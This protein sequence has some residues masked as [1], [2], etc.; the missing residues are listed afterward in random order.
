MK[1]ALGILGW[2]PREFWQA[3][4]HEFNAAIEGLNEKNGGGSRL[5]EEQVAELQRMRD[6]ATNGNS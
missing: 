1:A 2:S 4:P 3:T 5:T 6:G